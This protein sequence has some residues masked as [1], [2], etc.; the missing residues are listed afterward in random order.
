MTN[1][2]TLFQ[3]LADDTRLQ[4]LAL[5]RQHG[6]LCVCDL[7]H[8]LD[9]TQSK[10][11]RHLRYLYNAGLVKDRRANVWIHYRIAEDLT[12]EQTVILDNAQKLLDPARV[13]TLNSAL[14]AWKAEK[15][16]CAP[17]RLSASVEP[18][19]FTGAAR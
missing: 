17:I 6:E 3:A 5:L 10:A 16:G 9:I 7:E 11:S 12:A 1:P 13:S 4:M 15:N 19:E 14:A 18:A 2:V 8:V